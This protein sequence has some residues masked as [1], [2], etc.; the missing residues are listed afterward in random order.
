MPQQFK[1][2]QQIQV[3]KTGVLNNEKLATTA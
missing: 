3:H 1:E 2:K